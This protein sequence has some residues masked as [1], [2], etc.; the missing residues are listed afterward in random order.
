MPLTVITIKNSPNSLRGDL[1]K[2]MQEI[3]SGVYVGNFNSKIREELWKRVCQNIKNGEATLSY[4]ARNEIGYNFDTWQTHREVIDYDGIPLVY[5]PKESKNKKEEKT[6]GFSKA[7]KFHQARKF[8]KLKKEPKEQTETLLIIH[9]EKIGN[10]L[11]ISAMKEKKKDEKEIKQ[12]KIGLENNQNLENELKEFIKFVEEIDIIG[13]DIRSHIIQI[14]NKLKKQVKG[15]IK[16]KIYD[17]KS[18]VKKERLL[19]DYKLETVLKEY[20]IKLKEKEKGQKY[21]NA[22]KELKAKLIKK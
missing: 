9:I 20:G 7:Y 2:W 5:F 3:A 17:L 6:F 15:S 8:R 18:I 16:N 12:F 22:L 4:S 19:L 21:L 13:Y 10:K 1:T 11:E 14:K